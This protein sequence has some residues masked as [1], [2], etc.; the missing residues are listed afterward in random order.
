MINSKALDGNTIVTVTPIEVIED[1]MIKHRSNAANKSGFWAQL[2]S[3]KSLYSQFE[4]ALSEIDDRGLILGET[5]TMA[6]LHQSFELF[7]SSKCSKKI[8]FLIF[9]DGYLFSLKR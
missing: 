6:Y 9:V 4:K 3:D 7:I 5:Q 2:Q 8:S 1:Y